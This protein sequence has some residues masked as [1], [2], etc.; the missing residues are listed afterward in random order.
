MKKPKNPLPEEQNSSQLISQL[1]EI[2]KMRAE[3]RASL[4]RI[5]TEVAARMKA[6][7]ADSHHS[8]P[9]YGVVGADGDGFESG[10]VDSYDEEAL[11]PEPGTIYQVP[12]RDR[13]NGLDRTGS[14]FPTLRPAREEL[15]YRVQPKHPWQ[16][17]LS[18]IAAAIV[19]V[20][21]TGGTAT[22][23]SVMQYSRNLTLQ[24]E[25]NQNGGSNVPHA[26]H[27]IHK[28]IYLTS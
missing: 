7:L 15:E 19:V 8:D 17:R 3:D 22:L 12:R 2:Y 10:E 14:F 16:H 23:F 1:Q 20:L 9:M 6:R 21:L 28:P 5:E 13:L 26:A 4:V 18:L 11:S 24:S 27:I 25:K